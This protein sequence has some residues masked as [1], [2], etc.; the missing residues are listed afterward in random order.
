MGTKLHQTTVTQ[1]TAV[2]PVRLTCRG[3]RYQRSSSRGAATSPP[4][5]FRARALESAAVASRYRE[6][7]QKWRY[8][9]PTVYFFTVGV[10]ETADIVDRAAGR[11][12]HGELDYADPQCPLDGR[13][14]RSADGESSA[15]L[16][17]R[18]RLLATRRTSAD[19][20]MKA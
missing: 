20:F 12:L 17:L 16:P 4:L 5:P 11:S 1:S 19:R 18:V 13:Q 14:F 10:K 3:L 15:R 2:S 6:R 9:P 8:F 7:R